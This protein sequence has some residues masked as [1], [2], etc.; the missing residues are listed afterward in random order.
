LI[1]QLFFENHDRLNIKKF[2]LLCLGRNYTLGL[3]SRLV[4]LTSSYFV[5]LG[6]AHP[7]SV[8]LKTSWL[9]I[10]PV[11][12]GTAGLSRARE[13]DSHCI[14]SLSEPRMQVGAARH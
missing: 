12:K 3:A 11:S 1:R 5:R 6:C 7:R 8:G 2:Q 10:W 13:E 9:K 14:I 4:K